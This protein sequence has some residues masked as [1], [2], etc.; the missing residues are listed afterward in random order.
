MGVVDLFGKEHTE[1][2]GTQVSRERLADVLNACFCDIRSEGELVPLLTNRFVEAI[3]YGRLCQGARTCMLT[4][5]L[6]NPHR[7]SVRCLGKPSVF[8]SIHEGAWVS[9]LARAAR[10]QSRGGGSAYV[11]LN[12][13]I[14]V[15]VNS[16]QIAGEF[17]PHVARDLCAKFCARGGSVLDPCAGWGGRML[18]ISAA[19]ANYIAFEPATKTHRGLRRLWA[20]IRLLRPE[21]IAEVHCLPFE[22]SSLPP[23]AFDFAI[24]SPPYYNTEE[25]SDEGSNSLRRY[26]SFDEWCRG[27]FEPLVQ[28]TMVALKGDGVFAINIG[29]RKY[30]LS[31]ILVSFCR[32]VGYSVARLPNYI[33]HAGVG[34]DPKKGEKFYA[35]RRS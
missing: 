7:L 26:H 18:G 13:A 12:R 16:A 30:P 31:E 5:L 23:D 1:R 35:I 15:G 21:F 27:F 14:S 24:T 3:E 22:D 28:K 25:Y 20:F 33:S 9:G 34:R 8:G 29:D 6:F 32:R 10:M 19:G 4:S 11:L 2:R 17:P